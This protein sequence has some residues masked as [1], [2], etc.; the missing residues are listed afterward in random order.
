MG[1][2]STHV[3]NQGGSKVY[4]CF[5]LSCASRETCCRGGNPSRLETRLIW[6][7]DVP[8]DP[9]FPYFVRL[10]TAECDQFE[11]VEITGP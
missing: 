8:Q 7:Y 3:Y 11:Q 4:Q 2:N 10:S 1:I 9:P 6:C 5:H